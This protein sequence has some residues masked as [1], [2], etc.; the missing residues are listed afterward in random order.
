MQKI[1]R[2]A[3]RCKHC[4]DII[5]SKHR[6]DFVSCSCGSCH[7]DG[8]LDYFRRGFMHSPEE[9]FIDLSETIEVDDNSLDLSLWRRK[10]SCGTTDDVQGMSAKQ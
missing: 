3:I 1:I 7:V 10:R 8:G 6:H 4:G 9:D 2:N 5:E